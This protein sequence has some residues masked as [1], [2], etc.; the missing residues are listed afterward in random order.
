MVERDSARCLGETQALMEEGGEKERMA[1]GGGGKKGK[2]KKRKREVCE[3][4]NFYHFS[5]LGV[6]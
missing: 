5:S 3:R 1:T 4:D 6:T 2:K